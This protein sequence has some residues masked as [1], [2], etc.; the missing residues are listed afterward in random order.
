MVDMIVDE[1]ALGAGDGVFDR[2]KLLRNIDAGALLFDHA[3]DAT[4]MTSDAVEP[5]DD[6]GVAGVSVMG[7]TLI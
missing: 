7:H 1:R 3:D 2:L 5:F 4:Q 6:C